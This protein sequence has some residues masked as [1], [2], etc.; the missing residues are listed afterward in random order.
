VL[1]ISLK[2]ELGVC[3]ESIETLNYFHAGNEVIR[4]RDRAGKESSTSMGTGMAGSIRPRGDL[5]DSLH[6][7]GMAPLAWHCLPKR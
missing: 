4:F 2:P 6:R 5:P 3:I 7:G 1:A